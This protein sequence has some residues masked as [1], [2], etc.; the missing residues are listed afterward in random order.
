MGG[1]GTS[2][3]RRS[4]WPRLPST[5]PQVVLRGGSSRTGLQRLRA[6][7]PAIPA[8]AFHPR[9]PPIPVVPRQVAAWAA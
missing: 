8:L 4:E 7:A 1:P 3:R 5:P 6:A 9:M 2:P